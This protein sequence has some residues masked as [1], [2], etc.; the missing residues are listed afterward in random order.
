[1]IAVIDYD[2]GNIQSVKKAVNALG[3]KAVLTSDP[4]VIG[5]ASGVILPGVGAFGAAME[6]LEGLN[7]CDCIRD[8][9]NRGIPFLGI[10]LG[11][12]LLFEDSEESPGV[13]G[14]GILKGH[15]LKIPEE[16][17]LRVPHIGWNELELSGSS[18]LFSGCGADH[19]VYFVH[20]YYLAASDRNI[21][22]AQA[23]YGVKIDAAVEHNNIFAV[24]FHPEKSG[25]V[26]LYILKQFLR[27]C[28]ENSHVD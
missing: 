16:G 26:G 9:C 22:T 24:Q 20:S 15:I 14:L 27:L 19:F 21:V 11:L 2:A 10:C 5:A 6:R 23:S 25:E 17:G 4:E 13:K 1:M 18:R 7:L 28:Q 3:S 8:A 12:Q